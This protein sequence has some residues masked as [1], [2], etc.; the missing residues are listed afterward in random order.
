MESRRKVNFHLAWM[1]AFLVAVFAV[2]WAVDSKGQYAAERD[3]YALNKK[4]GVLSRDPEFTPSV[5][6]AD[7][8][9][10]YERFIEKHPGTPTGAL[11]YLTLSRI[12]VMERAYDQA[13][14]ALEKM[15]ELYSG[16]PQVAVQALEQKLLIYANENNLKATLDVLGRMQTQY[17]RTAHGLKAPIVRYNVFLKNKKTVEAGQ[18]LADAINYYLSVTAG[19]TGSEFGLNASLMLAQA[20]LLQESWEAAIRAWGDILINYGNTGLLDSRQAEDVVRS[21]NTVAVTKLKSVDAVVAI[22]GK[23][24]EAYPG[25]PFNGAIK[26]M[27]TSLQAVMPAPAQP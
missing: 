7:L 14:A 5:S 24:M 8:A 26:S 21:M 3:L 27:I 17:P 6:Y 25:H 10:E 4:F 20:Y 13:H 2:L 18:A 23:F 19:N 22:Y 12:R 15:L 9:K 1:A 11:A 16:D